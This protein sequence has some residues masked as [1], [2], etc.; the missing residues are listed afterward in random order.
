MTLKL[1]IELVPETSWF[2]NVRSMV[3]KAQWDA[4]KAVVFSKA[5][6]M[7][8]ICGNVGSRHPV[9]CHEI[10]HY[11]DHDKI[12]TLTGM[13]ALCPDCHMVKHYGLAEVQGRE[14]HA[15]LHFKKINKLRSSQ[16]RAHVARAFRVWDARSNHKWKVDIS[17]LHDYGIDASKLKEKRH[18][19]KQ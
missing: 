14:H 2:S 6:Y 1:S 5:Y 15:F 7:C 18:A 10:W 16:A 13:I 12:R 9:E 8:E 4:I 3:T 11:N 17:H 19:N